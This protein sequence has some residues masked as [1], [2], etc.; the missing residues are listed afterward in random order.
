MYVPESHTNPC[1]HTSRATDK[2]FNLV[3][4]FGVLSSSNKKLLG[5]GMKYVED[6]KEEW[7]DGIDRH[8][9]REVTA[10]SIF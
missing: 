9:E 6:K 10:V 1:R 7:G 5:K 4:L 2:Q 3:L 8:V